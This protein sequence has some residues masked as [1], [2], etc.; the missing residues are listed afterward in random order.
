MYKRQVGTGRGAASGI[1]VKSAEALETAHG[2]STVMLD[3]TGTITQMCIR[4]RH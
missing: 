4:D 3:K 1:L 2:I